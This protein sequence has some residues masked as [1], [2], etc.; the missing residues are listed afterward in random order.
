MA[1]EQLT[2]EQLLQAQSQPVFRATIE[3]IVGDATQVLVTP[4]VQGRGC[5]CQ[6]ALKIPKTAIQSLALT[7][8]SHVCC[9][10]ALQVVQ[11]DF[12]DQASMRLSE[13]FVQISAATA[14]QTAATPLTETG[15]PQRTRP[16]EG[17]DAEGLWASAAA[18][19]QRPRPHPTPPPRP[20]QRCVEDYAEA[21]AQC[22]VT[23]MFGDEPH[24]GGL[25][26]CLCNARNRFCFCAHTCL[27]Q[28]CP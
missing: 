7:G 18:P 14:H 9:G 21:Y 12:A 23:Y 10:K 4:W 13:V 26:T 22:V 20:S 6:L 25:Q 27:P 24:T 17:L 1:T 5:L 16:W 28:I 19:N 15:H 8:E 2:V 3:S 11:V